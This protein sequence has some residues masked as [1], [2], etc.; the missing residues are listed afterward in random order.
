MAH[1]FNNI[2][3][4]IRLNTELIAANADDPLTRK[5]AA[6]VLE[7]ADRAATLTRRAL[8]FGADGRE[9]PEPIDPLVPLE[10]AT[11]A[12]EAHRPPGVTLLAHLPAQAPRITAEHT[13]LYQI[14][15][16]LGTNAFQAVDVGGLVIIGLD[17]VHL[18]T[19]PL[20]TTP[21]LRTTGQLSPGRYLRLSV[22]DDG[23]GIPEESLELIFE[24]YFTTRGDS[25]TGLGLAIVHRCVLSMAGAI[26]VQLRPRGTAFWVWIPVPDAD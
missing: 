9:E 3:V 7:A 22:T 14:L 25:G 4:A 5:A 19:P 20:R 2:L 16:N 17:E 12:L 18:A 26:Q 11:R 8:A 15:L 21:N 1:D 23:A 24:P 6:D 10:E 13:D